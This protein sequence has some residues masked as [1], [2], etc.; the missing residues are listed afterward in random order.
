[1]KRVGLTARGIEVKKLV[2]ARMFEPP[3]ELLGLNRQTLESLRRALTKLPPT[4]GPMG[5][6]R[7]HGRA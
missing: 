7:G 6:I 5:R 4:S 1:M 2:F 3:E